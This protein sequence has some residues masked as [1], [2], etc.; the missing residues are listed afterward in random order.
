L[1]RA[2]ARAPGVEQSWLLSHNPQ[3]FRV[4]VIDHLF[5]IG[6]IRK[7]VWRLWYPFLTRRLHGEEVLFLNY[8]FENEPPMQIPLAPDDEK[9]RA[10]IQ[11]YQHVAT[12]VP[13]AGKKVLE[14]S[15]GHGGGASYL[16]RTLQPKSY[17]ALD[18]NP[19]GII[20]CKKRHCVA[21]L[22]FIQGD[23][24]NLPMAANTFDV[25]INVEA[26]HCYPNFPR[27]LTEVA[28]VLRPGGHFL[29]ADF[30]FRE[31]WT[32]W[33]SALAAA[34]LQLQTTRNINA[35]VLRGMAKNSARSQDLIARQ[36][37]KFLHGVGRDFAGTQ[38]SRIYNALNSG[39]LAYR[40]Y[41][42][43]KP[44]GKDN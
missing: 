26:S 15:C 32:E 37:P 6:R 8:A 13:L 17:T 5:S 42:F 44:V 22:D 9:N 40:S 7:A 3:N 12:Q 30:R 11:L 24:E 10:C 33:E 2:K 43:V 34:P 35:E 36:L 27:F 29:Y 25:V 16:A 19:A 41:C 18:L 31:R 20:F 38:G 21:G 23:A 14:V 4:P 1:K 28:R 39:D